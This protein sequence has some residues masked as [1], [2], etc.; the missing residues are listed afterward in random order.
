MNIYL[1]LSIEIKIKMIRTFIFKSNTFFKIKESIKIL[2]SIIILNSNIISL[3]TF[4]C[5]MCLNFNKE[6]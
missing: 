2:Y 5:I 1:N 4:V 6:C 3:N